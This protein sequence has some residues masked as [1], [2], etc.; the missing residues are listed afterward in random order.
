MIVNRSWLRLLRSLRKSDDVDQEIEKRTTAIGLFN[1]A[2]TYA[3]SASALSKIKVNATHPDSVVRFNYSH[4]VE[5]YLK[6]FL[7]LN[8]MSVSELSSKKYGHDTKKLVKKAI[9]CGLNLEDLQKYQI[10]SLRD[11]IDDRYI[12]IGHRIVLTIESLH[13][14]SVH[15]H[16]EIGPA[17]YKDAGIKRHLPPPG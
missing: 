16:N 7:R 10:I 1:F 5:L 8:G 15:L 3:Q 6:S 11:A 2:H 17:I 14:L 12:T 9:K 4:A 13:D